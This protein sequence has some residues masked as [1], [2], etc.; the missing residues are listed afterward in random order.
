MTTF[1]SATA[2][3]RV[4]W[5]LIQANPF[6]VTLKRGSSTLAVQTVR[7]E[8]DKATQDAISPAGRGSERALMIFG[9]RNHPTVANT[10]LQKG[11][12]F[13]YQLR[14]YTLLDPIYPLPGGEVQ[15]RAEAVA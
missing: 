7:M 13:V 15:C 6:S 1:M 8:Y 2:R 12:R 9:V 10:D 5:Q 3:A 4:I 11:D 14:E